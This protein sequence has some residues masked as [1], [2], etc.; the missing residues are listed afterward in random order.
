MPLISERD[1]VSMV[2]GDL[3]SKHTSTLQALSV[4]EKENLLALVKNKQL[5]GILLPLAQELKAQSSDDVED[6]QLRNAILEAEKEAKKARKTVR[7]LKGVLSGMVVGSGVN[8]AEDEVLRELV[9][10]DEED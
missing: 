3:A 8:W 4:A 6:P 1:V 10:N 7:L 5:A 9:M 2:H